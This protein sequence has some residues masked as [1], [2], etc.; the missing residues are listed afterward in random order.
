MN[1][2]K[3]LGGFLKK[4]TDKNSPEKVQTAFNVLPDD[5]LVV[6]AGNPDKKSKTAE[7]LIDAIVKL[8]DIVDNL[9]CAIISGGKNIG[10]IAIKANESLD[11]EIIY[12]FDDNASD[13]VCA[14]KLFVG[15]GSAAKDAM[16]AKKAVIL[17]GDGGYIGIFDESKKEM[18]ISTDFI[19]K[20]E[21]KPD[22]QKLAQDI[23]EF[24]GLWDDEQEQFGIFAHQVITELEK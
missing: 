19:C 12:I 20:N 15:E 24:F 9:K 23:G 21:T 1:I 4:D 10:E 18:C 5:K 14:S 2:F 6:Y 7:T 8:S 17:A 16:R 22:S 13:I 3:A 11:K